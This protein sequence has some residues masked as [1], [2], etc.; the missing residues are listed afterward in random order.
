[1]SGLPRT[2]TTTLNYPYSSSSRPCLAITSSSSSAFQ[3]SFFPS[4]AKEKLGREPSNESFSRTD[5]YLG[6]KFRH[7][8]TFYSTVQPISAEI[9][10][11]ILDERTSDPLRDAF[12]SSSHKDLNDHM[13]F[14]SQKLG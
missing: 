3:I 1:M 10:R 6:L 13:R 7:E 11:Q 12:G 5:P 14:G 2:K 9:V 8:Y 4:I